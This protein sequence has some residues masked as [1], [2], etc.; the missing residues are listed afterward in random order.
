MEEANECGALRSIFGLDAK[1]MLQVIK[2]VDEKAEKSENLI[3]AAIT[4][5]D[6]KVDGLTS[7]VDSLSS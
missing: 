4:Q 3:F 6:Q 7:K 2:V 1:Q 5:L